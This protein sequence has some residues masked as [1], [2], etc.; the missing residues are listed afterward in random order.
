MVVEW[1]PDLN[2]KS[3]S[4]ID[5]FHLFLSLRMRCEYRKQVRLTVDP[6]SINLR[7]DEPTTLILIT[8][9]TLTPKGSFSLAIFCLAIKI[10]EYGFN[11]REYRGQT[12]ANHKRISY[13]IDRH[14]FIA[15]ARMT[16]R[17]VQNCTHK[18]PLTFPSL[19]YSFVQGFEV[20]SKCRV[21]ENE[22]LQ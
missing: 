9:S 19:N 4:I 5:P 7:M 6:Q 18:Q 16:N 11:W 13:H 17:N 22:Y 3:F 21:K 8:S 14:G 10:L 1:V 20:Q 12:A 2:V 15:Y